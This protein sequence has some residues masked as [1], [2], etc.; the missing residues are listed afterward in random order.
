VVESK[1]FEQNSSI[2]NAHLQS[3]AAATVARPCPLCGAAER[4]VL[5]RRESWEIVECASCGMVFIG[6][7]L[8]YDVQ[9]RDFDWEEQHA[10]E[11]ERRKRKQP[12][13]VFLSRVLKP[14]RPHTTGRMLSQTLRWTRGGKLVDFGCGD[15]G[16][17]LLAKA[18]FDVTGIELSP[19]GA[20][21]SRARISPEAIWEGPVTEMAAGLP[22]QTYDVVTQFG[23]LEHEWAPIAGLRAAHRLL[24]P[25]GLTVIKT[26][27]YASWNRTIRGT[28]WCG[29]HIPAHCNYF[30]PQT[31]GEILR[32]AGFEPLPRP[33]ADRLPTSDSLWMAARKPH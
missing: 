23:Y 1:F 16:F 29:Y 20:E 10:Q 30:T 8:A 33:L 3:T 6:G 15:G 14:L 9:A 28:Q 5:R 7:E 25:G 2:V 27:N 11:A 18:H 26:P 22:A 32:R 17:L 31:L 19:R 13:F 4:R 12:A 24:R 21:I